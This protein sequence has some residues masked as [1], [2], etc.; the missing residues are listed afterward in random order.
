MY[1]ISSNKCTWRYLNFKAFEI[2]SAALKEWEAY[3]K[4]RGVIP[5]KF[6]NFVNF[7]FQIALKNYPYD[8]QFLIFQN[9]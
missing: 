5:M 7:S 3:F 6:Q 2:W 1:R 9:Y 4:V 8:I